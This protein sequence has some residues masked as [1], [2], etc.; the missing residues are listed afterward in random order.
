MHRN[1]KEIM[2]LANGIIIFL[3]CAFLFNMC[4]T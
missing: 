3:V 1:D 4:S 2:T